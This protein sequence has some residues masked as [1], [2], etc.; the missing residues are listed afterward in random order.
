MLVNANTRFKC[1]AC[2][3]SQRLGVCDDCGADKWK[4]GGLE[5]PGVLRCQNCGEEPTWWVC[6]NE[7][8][9]PKDP[10]VDRLYSQFVKGCGC[11]NRFLK[12]QIVRDTPSP[13]AGWARREHDDRTTSEIIGYRIGVVLRFLVLTMIIVAVVY[14]WTK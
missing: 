6:V 11:Q 5:R 14:F 8:I 1:V 4:W 3:G 13:A 7:K 2:G 10:N 9:G 12:K